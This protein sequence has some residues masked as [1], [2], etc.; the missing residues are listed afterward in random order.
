MN[1]RDQ[2]SAMLADV[3]IEVNGQRPWDIQV[4]NDDLFSRVIAEGT[5]GLGEAYMD[6]W[7]DSPQLDEFFHRV[8][9]ADLGAHLKITPS[10]AWLAITSHLQNR[11]NRK[12]AFQVADVHYNLDVDVFEATFDARLTGS[13]AYWE[14]AANLDQAQDAKLDLIC[15]KIGLERGQRVI[16]IG[17]GWGAF[18]GYAA[19]KYGA[20]CIGVTVSSEQ[21]AYA[22]E[23]Y[24]GMAVDPQL[25]DYR[26]YVG[27]VD[28]VVSMGMFEH[29]GSK[30]YRTYFEKARSVLKEG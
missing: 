8:V 20:D 29:V 23:R 10:L 4:H 25:M 24:Q 26:A 12:R 19:E 6:G 18:M 1:A 11:Q 14:N 7:W 17:C 30:N 16:D 27:E 21:V 2:L 28:H 9:A 3:D 15:R 5:L 22:R 13:C